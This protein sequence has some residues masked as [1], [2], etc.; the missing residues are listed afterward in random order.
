[1]SF[2]EQHFSDFEDPTYRSDKKSNKIW[3]KVGGN[4]NNNN[5]D[6]DPVNDTKNPENKHHIIDWVNHAEI[7]QK[8]INKSHEIAEKSPAATHDPVEAAKIGLQQ[9]E[10]LAKTFP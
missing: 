6:I 8:N 9:K 3:E 5:K 1:M 2:E 7:T 10:A 4:S